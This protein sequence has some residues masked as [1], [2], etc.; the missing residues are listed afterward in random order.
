MAEELAVDGCE[1]ACLEPTGT[2]LWVKGGVLSS[3]FSTGKRQLD[4]QSTALTQVD[5]FEEDV[6]LGSIAFRGDNAVAI[7]ATGGWGVVEAWRPNAAQALWTQDLGGGNGGGLSCSF[8][9]SGKTVYVWGQ[10]WWTPRLIDAMTGTTTLDLA[11]R[12]IDE[13]IPLADERFVGAMGSE[14]LE[15]IDVHTGKRRW[16]R[17]ET[18]NDGW[19]LHSPSLYVDGTRKALEEIQ[20]MLPERSYHLDA[21]ATVLL[22]PKRVRAEAEGVAI[23]PA[24][25]PPIPELVWAGPQLRVVRLDTSDPAPTLSLEATC[26]DGVAGFELLR[27]GERS[28]LEGERIDASHR[29]LTWTPD[30]IP[31]GA[32]HLRFRSISARGISSRALHLTIER[33]P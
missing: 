13:L 28:R 5:P 18:S 11:D 29:R 16:A 1:H 21:L 17:I 6:W 30:E 32:T 20:L 31:D 33:A 2:R 3:R 24:E 14:G 4:L 7:T 9:T 23:R 27:N 22:D 19:L 10:G 26:P 15:V 25:L 8:G 12:E